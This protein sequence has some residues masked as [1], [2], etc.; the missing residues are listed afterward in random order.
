[1]LYSASMVIENEDEK[2]DEQ[3]GFRVTRA[4]KRRLDAVVA[5][6]KRKDKRVEVT[7]I[8]TELMSLS[9]QDLIWDSDRQ[10]AANNLFIEGQMTYT[11]SGT[12]ATV[13]FSVNDKVICVDL[14]KPHA[15]WKR[16][17]TFRKLVQTE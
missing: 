5:R 14:N 4:N 12:M 16:V 15:N 11:E 1:M 6:I 8:Y 7:E 13:A 10:L 3:V 17:Y 2:K 9:P